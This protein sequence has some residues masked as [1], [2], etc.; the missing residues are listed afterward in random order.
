MGDLYERKRRRALIQCLGRTLW[1]YWAYL[2]AQIP[3]EQF[4]EF[5]AIIEQRNNAQLQPPYNDAPEARTSSSGQMA[6][7]VRDR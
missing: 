6:A 1:A 3:A 4:A 7:G 2:T 5:R